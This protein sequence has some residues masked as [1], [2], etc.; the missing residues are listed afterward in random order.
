MSDTQID[1]D[2]IS[3]VRWIVELEELDIQNDNV[4]EA[5]D[6]CLEGGILE[7]FLPIVA[8]GAYVVE[9]EGTEAWRIVLPSRASARHVIS[10]FGGKLKSRSSP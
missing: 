8:P 5:L 7:I 4:I 6:S 3:A 10:C 1:T 9:P 2:N